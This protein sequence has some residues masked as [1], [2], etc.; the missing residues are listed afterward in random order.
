M[1]SIKVFTFMA[2]SPGMPDGVVTAYLISTFTVED[3]A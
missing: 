3:S 2:D 1:L